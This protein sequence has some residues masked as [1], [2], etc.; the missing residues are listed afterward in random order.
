[1]SGGS[2][3]VVSLEAGSFGLFRTT[4]SSLRPS[5]SGLWTEVPVEGSSVAEGSEGSA[6]TGG[7]VT[8]GVVVAG[9]VLSDG[10]GS[11]G[12]A[13][14]AVLGGSAVDGSPVAPGFGLDCSGG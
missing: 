11:A 5:L 1:M 3:A 6:V 10:V 7:S 13:V 2:G 4:G 14:G 8:E 9:P 12:G